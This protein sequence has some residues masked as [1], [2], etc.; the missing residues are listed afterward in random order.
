MAVGYGWGLAYW[1][2]VLL[3]WDGGLRSMRGT[4]NR[5]RVAAAALLIA[6]VAWP[7]V[8]FDTQMIWDRDEFSWRPIDI[9]AE[10]V[11]VTAAIEARISSDE[12]LLSVTPGL[13]D[14]LWDLTRRVA[15]FETFSIRGRQRVIDPAAAPPAI[16]AFLETPNGETARG[17]LDLGISRVLL[18]HDYSA[19]MRIHEQ[20]EQSDALA[21]ELAG[22]WLTLYSI[23]GDARPLM[24][25]EPSQEASESVVRWTQRSTTEYQVQI[26]ASDAAR[27]L[28]VRER[29]D[30]GWVL[31]A[32]DLSV[33]P[34]PFGDAALQRE[35][36]LAYELPSGPEI[37]ATLS[38]AGAPWYVAGI[39]VSA[40]SFVAFA[41]GGVVTW[42]RRRRGGA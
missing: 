35:T 1:I 34:K 15:P 22:E 37:N 5:V 9:P 7:A 24:S 8:A 13:R 29:F 32:Q 10:F 20:F 36:L 38:F 27:Q 12:W 40:S 33:T 42:Q 31:S 4:G 11:E 19:G 23:E 16:N 17:L 39:A 18:V 3:G 14:P 25:L 6:A 28:V 2:A 26:P 21:P 30:A 41:T